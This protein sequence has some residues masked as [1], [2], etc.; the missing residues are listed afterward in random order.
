MVLAYRQRPALPPLVRHLEAQCRAALRAGIPGSPFIADPHKPE[1]LRL[2]EAGAPMP[3]IA[4]QVFLAEHLQAIAVTADDFG[5][6]HIRWR[7]PECL[8]HPVKWQPPGNDLHGMM[9][10]VNAPLPLDAPSAWFPEITSRH[11]FLE[12][13]PDTDVDRQRLWPWINETFLFV[14]ENLQAKGVYLFDP[15]EERSSALELLQTVRIPALSMFESWMR[16]FFAPDLRFCYVDGTTISADT[17]NELH[18][19]GFHHIGLA[20]QRVDFDGDRGCFPHE[21]AIHDVSHGQGARHTDAVGRRAFGQLCTEL[22]QLSREIVYGDFDELRKTI[23]ALQERIADFERE[24]ADPIDC[25]CDFMQVPLNLR[26]AKKIEIVIRRYLSRLMNE[27]VEP[28]LRGQWNQ[29]IQGVQAALNTYLNSAEDDLRWS[30]LPANLAEKMQFEQMAHARSITTFLDLNPARWQR[31]LEQ[32][33][34]LT[35]EMSSGGRRGF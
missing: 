20:T 32:W 18:R 11:R 27:P 29:Y 1:I 28:G 30:S 26:T 12:P 22:A 34:Q 31:T 6:L 17:I 35:R 33:H 19:L 4:D 7:E 14:A 5:P 9:R 10:L 16:C 24:Y 23:K 8:G 13:D 15:P 2:I 21:L 25:L 3:Q